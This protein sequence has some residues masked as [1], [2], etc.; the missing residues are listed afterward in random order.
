MLFISVNCE[1]EYF[2]V[3]FDVTLTASK[4]KQ[5]LFIDK[6]CFTSVNCWEDNR[7]AVEK[8]LIK[9]KVKSRRP[10]VF[11][12]GAFQNSQESTLAR[13]SFLIKLQTLGL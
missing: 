3:I 4:S 8:N 12:K 10:E 11:F 2:I 6:W 9:H 5:Y 7:I 13:F 1:F